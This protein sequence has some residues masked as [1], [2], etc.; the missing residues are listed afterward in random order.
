MSASRSD[1]AVRIHFLIDFIHT[2][3]H[4][5]QP[6]A[7]RGKCVRLLWVYSFFLQ[8]FCNYLL[9]VGKLV[10]DIGKYS[11]VAGR[12]INIFRKNPLFSLIQGYLRR[13]GTRIQYNHSIHMSALLIV[14]LRTVRPALPGQWNSF[15]MYRSLPLM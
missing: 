1:L 7:D 14:F 9:T 10:Y 13:G 4:R 8:G 6:C 2:A 5:H 11:Q 3:G 12:M 15:W